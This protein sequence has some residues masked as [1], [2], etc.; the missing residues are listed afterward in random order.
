MERR[1]PPSN[2]QTAQLKNKKALDPADLDDYNSENETL[3]QQSSGPLK[4]EPEVMRQSKF[5]TKID[6]I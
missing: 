4:D 1:V 3:E 5:A 6:L 2:A